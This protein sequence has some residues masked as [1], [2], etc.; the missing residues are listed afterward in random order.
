MISL[1]DDIEIQTTPE[2]IF[3]WLERMPQ[4]YRSWHPDHVSC[5]VIKG[6]MLEVGSEIECQEILHGKLHSM[7]F[8]LTNLVPDR[9][10]EFDVFGLGRGAFEVQQI[11][12]YSRFVAE[13]DIGTDIPVI[14]PLFDWIL[15]GFFQRRIEA[16]KQHMAE[17]G[18]NLKALMEEDNSQ[19]HAVA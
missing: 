15:S 5:R 18:R 19:I 14:G 7:R 4:D 2:C 6:S 13:L 11:G 12:E 10:I 8:R 3:T 9:R 17:E 1:K 16:M